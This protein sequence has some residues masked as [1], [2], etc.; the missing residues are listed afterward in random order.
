MTHLR[1]S[2]SR[3]EATSIVAEVG[4]NALKNPQQV[5]QAVGRRPRMLEKACAVA[6][7]QRQGPSNTQRIGTETRLLKSFRTLIGAFA[8]VVVCA[9]P[10][11]AQTTPISI[12]NT[13]Y[14]QNF[15]TM[16]TTTE[17]STYPSGWNGYKITG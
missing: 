10:T 16:G 8:T 9:A 3:L 5:L 12:G 2:S 14:F 7:P 15:D 1:F 13:N 6:S 11:S 17:T 4:A